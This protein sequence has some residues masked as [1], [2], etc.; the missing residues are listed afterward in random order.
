[1]VRNEPSRIDG[2][3]VCADVVGLLDYPPMYDISIFLIPGVWAV[4]ISE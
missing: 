3:D 1:M 4:R 2:T